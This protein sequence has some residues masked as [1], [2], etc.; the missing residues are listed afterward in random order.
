MGEKRKAKRGTPMARKKQRREDNVLD[1]VMLVKVYPNHPQKQMLKRWMG[2]ARFAY[3]AVVNW[4]RRRRCYTKDCRIGPAQQTWVAARCARDKYSFFNDVRAGKDADQQKDAA[5]RRAAVWGEQKFCRITVRVGM[6]LQGSFGFAPANITDEA[7]DEALAARD[8]VIKRNMQR[9]T[10]APSHHLSFRSRKNP[11]HTISIRA[12]N[13]SRLAW[14]RFYISHLHD[15]KT[16]SHRR[17]KP[18]DKQE[19]WPLHFEKKRRKNSWPLPHKITR[20]CKLTYSWKT[21]DWT[22]AWVHERQKQHRETQADG[23]V[24][25]VSID[26]GVRTPF[27]WYSPTKGTGKIGQRD[28]GRVVRLCQH[29]DD[30]ISRMDRLNES[31][32]KR[33]KRKARRLAA[34]VARMRRGIVRLQDEIHRKAIAFFVREFD[35]IVIPPFEVSSMVNRKT[36][37]ITRRTVRNMLSW[38]H[39]R[40]RRRLISKAEEAGVQVIV[41]DEAYT[42]K[43]CSWCGNMQAIGGSEIY[44]CRGCKVKIDRDENGA[45]G[46]FLRA[47]LDGALVLS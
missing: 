34:A 15:P 3:N 18:V 40:F 13:F 32:S 31:S 28:I 11:S 10:G 42:S 41:Q 12:Q 25:A 4:S 33:K 16:L 17:H 9:E 46:I 14:N 35:A 29:M 8:E 47:L 7:I 19:Y 30:L 22:L 24:H 39:F 27:T 45:R 38:A 36:R 5:L 37:R 43:T 20:D 21:N 2:L 23:S 26:P 44:N 1:R 6:L